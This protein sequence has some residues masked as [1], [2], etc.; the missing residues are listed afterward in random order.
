M[1]IRLPPNPRDKD[2]EDF[3]T[4]SLRARGYFVEPSL[5]LRQGRVEVLE[6]DVIATPASD[7]WCNRIIVEAKSGNW[8]FRDIFKLYGWRMHVGIDRGFIMH[9][10]ELD[11][12]KQAA[13]RSIS[14][15]TSI[16]CRRLSLP[17]LDTDQLPQAAIAIG[18]EL[19]PKVIASDWYGRIARR[20]GL[21]DFNRY[22]RDHMDLTWVK[23][24]RLYRQRIQQSVFARTPL[25]RVRQLYTAWQ[26]SPNLPGQAVEELALAR[27]CEVNRIWRSLEN[28]TQ[29][30]W[31]QYIMTLDHIARIRIIK[32]ALDCALGCGLESDGD[33]PIAE[34]LLPQ[35]FQHGL[36]RLKQNPHREKIPF[37][38]QLFTE[39][40]GGFCLISVDDDFELM[41]TLTGIPA[42]E[43]RPSL[44]MMNDFFE[45]G[46][47]W[48]IEQRDEIMRFRVNPSLFLG[49]GCFFRKSVYDLD[50]YDEKF[51]Q[52]G[53]LLR[54]WHNALYETL[55]PHLSADI[56]ET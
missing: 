43:V 28:T 56:E 2:Y 53:W 33:D 14:L 51:P 46:E 26:G 7:E 8:G 19:I 39:L 40:L 9:S 18:D 47:S 30:L 16:E 15:S 29:D 45:F 5:T 49:T 20:L 11:E 17:T 34:L 42:D 23:D 48:F 44:E 50:N 24:A 55:E 32:N 1:T 35:K 21:A 22:C 25:E 54:R 4:A 38:F 41:S 37:L 6:L 52:L 12:I 27:G 3:V 13:I 31:L 10:Q 36:E